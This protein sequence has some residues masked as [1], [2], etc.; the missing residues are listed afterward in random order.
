MSSELLYHPGTAPWSNEKAAAFERGLGK[1]IQALLGM[2]NSEHFPDWAR[3][4]ISARLDEE[5][6]TLR[7]LVDIME[8]AREDM[9]DQQALAEEPENQETFSLAQ[10]RQ[11][12]AR[13][14]E[15]QA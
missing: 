4:D 3:E 11:H 13:H 12:L 6:L 15:L 8:K 7:A 9:L 14:G 1:S 5:T 2:I 10:V